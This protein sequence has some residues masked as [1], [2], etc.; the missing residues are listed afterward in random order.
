MI[1]P[2]LFEFYIYLLT[3]ETPSVT[4]DQNFFSAGWRFAIYGH[5]QHPAI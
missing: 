1:N 2:L 4:V 5:K 3:P